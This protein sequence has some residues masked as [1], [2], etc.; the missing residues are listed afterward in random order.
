MLGEI[1][2]NEPILAL[3][4]MIKLRTLNSV[5]SELRQLKK[6]L[7][8]F[9]RIFN[10][11][12][13]RLLSFL[14]WEVLVTVLRPVSNWAVALVTSRPNWEIKMQTFPWRFAALVHH[15]QT[16]NCKQNAT[17]LQYS[18]ERHICFCF[19]WS[20]SRLCLINIF[21]YY[22]FYLQSVTINLSYIADL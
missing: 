17:T 5:Q 22:F 21:F 11:V 6:H 16:H 19:I 8:V 20:Q 1:K 13:Q 3:A 18:C 12:Q 7:S 14:Q 9:N 15:T 4:L 2:L 10:Q